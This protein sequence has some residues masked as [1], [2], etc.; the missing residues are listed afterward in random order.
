[1][2]MFIAAVGIAVSAVTALHK[3]RKAKKAREVQASLAQHQVNTNAFHNRYK[4]FLQQNITKASCC[5]TNWHTIE[6]SPAMLIAKRIS[7]RKFE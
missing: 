1:M 7:V 5:I 4:P 3:H 6:T 2:K